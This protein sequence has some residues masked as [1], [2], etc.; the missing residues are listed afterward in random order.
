ML[1][2]RTITQI[3][4]LPPDFRE[5]QEWFSEE[6]SEHRTE[7]QTGPKILL[8]KIWM[9]RMEILKPPSFMSDWKYYKWNNGT[10]FIDCK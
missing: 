1:W 3:N 2:K 10:L 6:D 7:H 4:L 5:L 9:G 8:I